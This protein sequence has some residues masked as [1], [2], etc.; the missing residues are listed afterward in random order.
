MSDQ[1]PNQTT[2]QAPPAQ[3][4]KP[5]KSS[6][7]KELVIGNNEKKPAKVLEVK[8]GDELPSSKKGLMII[9]LLAAVFV[10]FL[11]ALTT[12]VSN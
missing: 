12:W 5:L 10:M 7:P 1:E 6:P 8:A 11:A 9:A 2:N 4:E 3:V